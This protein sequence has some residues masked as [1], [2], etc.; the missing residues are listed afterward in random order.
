MSEMRDWFFLR[1]GFDNFKLD[2]R[3]H[4]RILIGDFDRKR[5]D[6]LITMLDGAARARHGQKSVIFGD[7]GRGKT[8]LCHNL[9][10][11][12]ERR[13]LA[14]AP[15]YIKCTEY[16]SKEKFSS[17]FRDMVLGH[18]MKELRR[19]ADAY[20]KKTEAGEAELLA[21]IVDSEDIALVM[22]TG[23]ILPA[24]PV[25]KR[26]MK[27]LSGE[28]KV[29]MTSVAQVSDQLTAGRDFAAVLRGLAH[30]YRVVD[31]RVLLYVI[32]EAER[33]EGVTHADTFTV[34]KSCFREITEVPGVSM[35]F[36]V[37]AKSRNDLPVMFVHPEIMRRVGA[38]NY[39]EIQ[40]PSK[41]Q[42]QDF[43]LELLRVKVR[44]GEVPE[45]HWDA[46]QGEALDEAL[47]ADLARLVGNDPERL[48]TYPFDPD[49]FSE[50]IEH[51]LAAEFGNKP[52]EALERLQKA[53]QLAHTSGKSTIDRMIVSDIQSEGF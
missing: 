21:D 35:I 37:G 38:A 9:L 1:A 11:E 43:I 32:D 5:R 16:E 28:A 47:P 27:W 48:L 20:V 34:W 52:S 42:L 49:A 13:K 7:Y 17:L 25:V 30:M 24:D 19:I 12:V 8:H 53:A 18:Q 26:C 36:L 2:P 41:E 23:L 10:Y 31:G 46:L 51:L 14:L 3:Q 29:D 45:A 39:I 40:N 6:Q 15:V 44:K 50:F 4:H 33:V 22:T